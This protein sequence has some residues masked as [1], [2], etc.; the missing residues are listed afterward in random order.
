MAAGTAIK[1]PEMRI[2]TIKLQTLDRT[3]LSVSLA[4]MPLVIVA[5]HE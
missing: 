4:D 1:L 2:K 3:F 5:I